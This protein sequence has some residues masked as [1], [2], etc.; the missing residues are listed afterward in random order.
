MYSETNFRKGELREKD[1]QVQSSNRGGK[2]NSVSVSDCENL[3]SLLMF[4]SPMVQSIF[5]GLGRAV[6]S[7]SHQ[8]PCSGSDNILHGALIA[9]QVRQRLSSCFLRKEPSRVRI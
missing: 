1:E 4:V 2:P 5:P 6:A 7:F 8:A 3:L 9:N